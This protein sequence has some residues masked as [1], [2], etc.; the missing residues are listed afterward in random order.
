MGGET[1]C[2]AAGKD[3]VGWGGRDWVGGMGDAGCAWLETGRGDTF[4]G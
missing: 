4:P 1:T 3:G 2:G